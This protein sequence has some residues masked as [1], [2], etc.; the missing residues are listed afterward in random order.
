MDPK[1]R[2]FLERACHVCQQHDNGNG[3]LPFDAWPLILEDL[4]INDQSPQCGILMEQLSNSSVEN[5]FSYRPLWQALGLSTPVL[6]GRSPTKYHAPFEEALGSRGNTSSCAQ[7]SHL[8]RQ[9]DSRPGHQSRPA[10]LD[11]RSLNHHDA[12]GGVVEEVNDAFWARRASR[13][14]ELY[15]GWDC[16]QLSNEALISRLQE[17]FGEA[18]DVSSPDSELR[19]LTDRYRSARNCKFSNIMTAL[20]RD[21]RRT[22][23]RRGIVSS[24]ASLS[25]YTGSQAS[26]FAHSEFGEGEVAPAAGR[27][28]SQASI[29]TSPGGR[30]HRVP[31]HDSRA[32]ADKACRGGVYGL[33]RQRLL[34]HD[35]LTE[36]ADPTTR[37][38]TGCPPSSHG[39]VS[40]RAE[41]SKHDEFS[42]RNRV[43][44]GNILTWESRPGAMVVRPHRP[45]KEV[46][47]RSASESQNPITHQLPQAWRAPP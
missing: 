17:V 38:S 39:D 18:V 12:A 43:G 46:G 2:D 11:Q 31:D 1:V 47:H 29:A 3:E 42:A 13:I 9:S 32:S 16:T 27:P 6:K 15:H 5:H 36:I 26:D 20:R 40:H 22:N 45:S 30:R 10:P 14:K 41:S 19:K 44:H 25:M 34:Q 33:D 24:Q 4:A 37:K 35:A 23:A 7:G 8:T 21:V 28:S